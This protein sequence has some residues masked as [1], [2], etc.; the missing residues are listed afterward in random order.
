M[1]QHQAELHIEVQ[2]AWWWYVARPLLWLAVL[3][4]QCGL[5]SP[6]A[7]HTLVDG[8]ARCAA[9]YRILPDGEWRRFDE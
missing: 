8:T 5:V 1:T 6:Y 7:V 2:L 9:R 3:F 4:T